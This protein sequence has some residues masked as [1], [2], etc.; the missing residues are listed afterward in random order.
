MLSGY[1]S[2]QL[3][4]S[5]H[6]TVCSCLSSLNWPPSNSLVPS[7]SRV[8]NPLQPFPLL[9]LLRPCPPPSLPPRIILPSLSRRHTP[10]LA[11]RAHSPP[12]VP[13]DFQQP[14]QH[15]PKAGASHLVPEREGYDRSL[16]PSSHGEMDQ[17]TTSGPQPAHHTHRGWIRRPPLVDPRDVICSP[18]ETLHRLTLPFGCWQNPPKKLS[19]AWRGQGI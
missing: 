1:F 4:S 14:S 18:S 13:L 17:R 8:G 12:R 3:T 15:P 11:K 5:H 16:L 2:R 10:S 19:A 6:C 7:R 9:D